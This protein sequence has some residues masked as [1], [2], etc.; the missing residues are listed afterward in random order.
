MASSNDIRAT[1][2][3]YFARNGHAVVESS[4]LVPRN[5]P[6]LMFTNA[7]HGAVQE[8][9]HRPGEAALHP[10]DHRAEMRARRRQAQRPGQRRLHRPA[11]HV[12]RNAG[13]FLLRRLFQGPGDPLRLGPADQGLRPAAGPADWSRCSARTTRPPR[14][15]RRSPGLPESADHPHPDRRTISGAWAIP[16]RAG[17]AARSSTTTAPAFPAGRRAAPTRTATGSS[18][19]GTWCSCSSRKG[20]PAPACRCRAPRSTPA[21][22]WSAF[23]AILQGKHD[24]YDTD[25][26]R[27]LILASAEA[28]GQDPD[29]PFKASHRVIADHLRSTAFLIADG[30]LPS[31][32]GARLRAA[33]DHA[34]R[35]APRPH[36]GRAG[37][38]DVPAGAGAG[39]PDGRRLP[40]TGARRGADRARR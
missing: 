7:R 16:A 1:F 19:S 39:A 37:A 24:N 15:G 10:R 26:F 25:T 33:P 29:G 27:A 21:W 13:E 5:D 11:P 35:H 34:P 38:G 23:A 40:R 6:T 22:G 2:L 14:C 28:T 31:Q 20:R 4:P 30:V 36:D 12:L 9:L 3:D 8:R 18:R 32:R 17:R